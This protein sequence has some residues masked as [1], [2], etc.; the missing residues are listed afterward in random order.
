MTQKPLDGR[1]ALVTGASS[2]LGRHF[3]VTLAKAGARLAVAARRSGRLDDLVAQI[4]D[5]GGHAVAVS[6]DVQ[7]PKSVRDA[8]AAAIGELGAINILVNNAGITAPKPALDIDEADWEA[9]LGTNLTGAWRVA[10]QTARHM[11]RVGD[12]GNIINIA[13]ILGHGGVTRQLSSYAIS[14]AAVVTMT[15]ALALDLA[16]DNIRV[17]AIAPGYIETDFNRAFFASD[18]GKAMIARIPQRRLGLASDLDAILLLLAG[19]GSA[20]M[21]GS[22]V[23]VDGGH[24]LA[25]A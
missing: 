12:G 5:F 14:K 25:I 20:F 21:T 19:D 13:S 8:V 1:A 10:T 11:V 18:A 6:L 17:N 7:D 16:R 24:S 15:K 23:T 22:I 4:A 2:G 3:A 9:V